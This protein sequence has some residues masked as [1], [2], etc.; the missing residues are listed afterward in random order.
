MPFLYGYLTVFTLEILADAT[1]TS[2]WSPVP[3]AWGTAVAVVF[4]ILG[5]L[6]Y[7]VLLG[8]ARWPHMPPRAWVAAS[9]LA[10]VVPIA[11][12]LLERAHPAPFSNPRTTFLLYELLF[13]LF[14]GALRVWLGRTPG[15]AKR[16]AIRVT[17]FEIVQYAL[18]ALADVVILAGYDA[19]F[20]LRLLPNTMYYVFFLPFVAWTAPRAMSEPWRE[21]RA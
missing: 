5:D 7:F 13:A 17:D 12:Q 11:S 2:A 6:R 15:E 9:A 8:R 21:A 18:W 1:L 16:W 10:L 4:V 20:A 14:A 3:P 19:G